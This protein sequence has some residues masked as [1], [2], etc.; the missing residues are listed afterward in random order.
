[1]TE[2]NAGIGVGPQSDALQSAMTAAA[3]SVRTATDA[4]RVQFAALGEA[5]RQAQRH[6][7]AAAMQIRSAVETLQTGARGLAETTDPRAF[8][9]TPPAA[10]SRV[11]FSGGVPQMKVPADGPDSGDGEAPAGAAARA[12][13]QFGN[14]STESIENTVDRTLSGIV[15][16]TTSLRGTLSTLLRS[17][18]GDLVGASVKSLLDPVIGAGSGLLG[19][20]F[21]SIFGSGASLLPGGLF[22]GLGSILAFSRGGIVPSAAGGWAVPSLGP[23]GVVARLHSREMVLP[24]EISSG[25]QSMIADGARGHTFNIGVSAIDAAGVSKLFMGNGAALVA[26]LNK[27]LRNGSSLHAG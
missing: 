15:I 12:A 8:V 22:A 23:D 13:R 24:A 20:L 18:L 17:L 9:A 14:S 11:P 10:L 26:A 5:A 4:M 7:A 1:M 16:G 25:L 21:G 6:L 2:T 3:N 27:A 19:G